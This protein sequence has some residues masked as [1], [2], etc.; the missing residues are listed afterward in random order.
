MYH[1]YVEYPC[2]GKSY[3][4][5]I[6][7]IFRFIFCFAVWPKKDDT[8]CKVNSKLTMKVCKF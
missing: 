5:K 4:I 7:Y 8:V 3:Q 2:R 6:V 1:A